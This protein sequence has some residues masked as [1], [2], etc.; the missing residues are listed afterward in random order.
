M[1]T[2]LRPHDDEGRGQHCHPHP[3]DPRRQRPRELKKGRNSLRPHSFKVGLATV[4][5]TLPLCVIGAEVLGFEW[6]WD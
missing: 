4:P 1:F 2:S 5:I 3:A 6:D